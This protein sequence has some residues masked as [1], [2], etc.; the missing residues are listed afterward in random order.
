M[1]KTCQAALKGI[2][3][4]LESVEKQI[5]N[6]IEEDKRLK[7]LFDWITS[8]PGIGNATATEL[9]VA[10]DEFIAINDAK[11]LAC[12]AGI[13]PF[14]YC[15]GSSVRDRTSVSQH[16]RKRLKLLF[17]LA[18]KSAIQ[19]KGE[20]QDYYQRK[21]TEGKNKMLVLN[22]VRNKLIHRVCSVVHRG[23]KYDKSYRPT[24][25]ISRGHL[26]GSRPIRRVRVIASLLT[27]RSKLNCF[28]DFHSTGCPALRRHLH[29]QRLKEPEV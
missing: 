28:M 27:D 19:V 1:S 14:G 21:T 2:Y 23:Q 24:P 13:D 8:I 11:K 25:C 16:A 15:S 26:C 7:E 10:T 12:H 18:A 6:L 5:R 22:A 4:D 17:H 29:Y 9:L 3:A 20:L